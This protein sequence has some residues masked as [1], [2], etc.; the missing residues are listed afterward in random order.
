MKR[1]NDVDRNVD[2]PRLV[3][4]VRWASK[5]MFTRRS[6]SLSISLSL[7]PM[8]SMQLLCY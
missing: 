1:W 2:V 8:H 6:V 4:S 7:R 5:R 3:K